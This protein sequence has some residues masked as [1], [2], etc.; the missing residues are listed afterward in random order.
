MKH[1]PY[2]LGAI[3]AL[4]PLT[5]GGADAA[6]PRTEADWLPVKDLVADAARVSL[7]AANTEQAGQRAAATKR[8]CVCL[9]GLFPLKE[10]VKSLANGRQREEADVLGEI[11]V[12]D[13]ALERQGLAA[14]DAATDSPQW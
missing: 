13:F 7:V 2:L 6:S 14:G 10:Q 8:H 11:D 3:V 9:R 4:I 1:L 5:A 12:L